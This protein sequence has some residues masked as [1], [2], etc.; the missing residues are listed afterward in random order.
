MTT[1]PR[2]LCL[3]EAAAHGTARE[4]LIAR[5]DAVIEKMSNGCLARD[6]HALDRRLEAIVDALALL[7]DRE[8]AGAVARAAATPDEPWGPV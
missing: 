7:D 2:N 8:A 3:A 1:T 5:R 4:L 6:Y